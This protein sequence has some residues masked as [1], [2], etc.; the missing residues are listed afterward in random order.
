M[1]ETAGWAIGS[2][3]ER[4]T[5][6]LGRFLGEILGPGTVVALMGEIGSGKTRLVQ[7]IASGLEVPSWDRVCSPSFALIHEHRGRIPFYHMDFFRLTS[8]RFEPDL[9]LYDYFQGNGACVIEWADRIEDWLPSDRLDVRLTIHGHRKRCMAFWA[10][11]E[12]HQRILRA[13]QR[14]VSRSVELKIAT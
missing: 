6:C 13:L 12:Q 3:G 9:G 8:G 5:F 7:G 1:P 10:R 14:K 11:G 4:Q 2:R